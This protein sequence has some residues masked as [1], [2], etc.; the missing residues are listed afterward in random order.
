MWRLFPETL[1]T[2]L[3]FPA[4]IFPLPKVVE[5]EVSSVQCPVEIMMQTSI[6]TIS[7]DLLIMTSIYSI[8]CPFGGFL[9]LWWF[10]FFTSL[11]T[12]R[13][14]DP[15]RDTY[16]IE[17]IRRKV[18]P[19]GSNNSYKIWSWQKGKC[20]NKKCCFSSSCCAAQSGVWNAICI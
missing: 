15:S 11:L 10:L 6:K 19:L 4:K 20:W 17:L 18:S 5:N 16:L 14:I 12:K 7:S 2:M 9:H 3:S 1:N 8:R 13:G